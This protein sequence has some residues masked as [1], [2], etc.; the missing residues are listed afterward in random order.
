[1]KKFLT[2]IGIGLLCVTVVCAALALTVVV[3]VLFELYPVEMCIGCLILLPLLVLEWALED[4][5]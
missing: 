5:K 3:G 2:R 4:I 1:M